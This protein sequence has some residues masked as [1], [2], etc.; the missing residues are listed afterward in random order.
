MKSLS[1]S[2]GDRTIRSVLGGSGWCGRW[3]LNPRTP[4]GR[5][6]SNAHSQEREKP[7][8]RAFDQAGLPP[9]SPDSF[10]PIR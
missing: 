9:Q 10:L 4:K 3:D 5:G 1:G 7:K 2:N 6:I 8:P